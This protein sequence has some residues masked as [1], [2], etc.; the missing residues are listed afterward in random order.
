MKAVDPKAT[1]V[2][3]PLEQIQEKLVAV[4]PVAPTSRLVHVRVQPAGFVVDQENVRATPG[5]VTPTAQT[6]R[7][8]SVTPFDLHQ[9]VVD[10]LGGRPA[11]W[12]VSQERHHTVHAVEIRRRA[13]GW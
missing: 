4:E 6:L 8:G 2:K 3:D 11:K 10:P 9:T 12:P 5:R 1:W 13:R 7:S